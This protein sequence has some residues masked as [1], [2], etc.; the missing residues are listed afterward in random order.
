MIA[1]TG[2]SG[3]LGRLVVKGLL[4]KVPGGQ[5]VA[6]ARNL[7]AVDDLRALGVQ[8]RRADYDSP[9]TLLEAF[10]GVETLLLVSA[11]QPGERFGQHKAV[12]DAAREA[13]VKMVAYTSILRAG[14]STLALAGEHRQT[15]EYLEQSGLGFVLLRNGWYLENTTGVLGMAIAQG[16]FIGSSAQGRYA[17][18]SR[19]DYADAAVAVLT[20]PGHANKIY[21]LAG[22]EPF[23]MATFA[24]E[25]SRQA[26]KPIAYNDLPAAQY[27]MALLSLGLPQMIVDVVVDASVKA[28]G[29]ELDSTSTDLARLIGRPTTSL[30]EAIK[31]AL[32]E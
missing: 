18:A 11:V 29:G 2:A 21:E 32:P 10:K 26:G 30:A 22:G 23:S 20:Q 12:I 14:T 9:Q 28:S 17:S 7:E 24:Q 27:E 1:V 4:K 6:T 25:A 16:A 31:A 15:E 8:V 5:I 19:A 3:H 13:G